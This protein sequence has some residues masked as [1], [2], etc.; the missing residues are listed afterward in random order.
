M[1]ELFTPVALLF[2][3]IIFIFL[4]FPYRYGRAWPFYGATFFYGYVEPAES[5]GIVVRERPD[6][7][8]RVGVNLD[9]IHVIKE[10]TNEVTTFL[11]SL[12]HRWIL[13]LTEVVYPHVCR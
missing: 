5:K 1:P 7:L 13:A 8:V 10:K 2:I 9:G 12:W 3:E 4:S 11:F 6:E